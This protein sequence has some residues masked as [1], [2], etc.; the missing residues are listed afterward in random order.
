MI[1]NIVY[2]DEFKMYSLSSQIFEGITEFLINDNVS[3]TENSESQ[4]GPVGSGRILAD[5]IRAG[6]RT[7]EKKFLHDYSYTVFEKH[8]VDNKKVLIVDGTET[9]STEEKLQSYSFIKVKAKAIFNDIN[10]I[11]KTLKEFNDIGK[12]LTY[13]TNFKEIEEVQ[14]QLNKSK[15]ELKDRNK[16]AVAQNK[17]NSIT[18]ISKIAKDSGLTQN[19]KY[20]DNLSL[21]LTYGFQN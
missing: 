13:V 11:N 6:S 15:T 17:I 14:S 1:K 21:L 2:L 18:N 16:R 9:S 7:T 12:A 4:K 3:E 10:S 8:L 5:V 19:Q 20:L